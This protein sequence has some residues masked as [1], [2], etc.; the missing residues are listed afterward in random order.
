MSS[1]RTRGVAGIGPS[2][3]GGRMELG[4]RGVGAA[5]YRFVRVC[6]EEE[7]EERKPGQPDKDGFVYADEVQKVEKAPP[8][9]ELSFEQKQ[10]LREEYLGIGG[11]QNKAIPNYFLYISIFVALLAILS[12]LLG[13]L[14]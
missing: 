6:A 12:K 7:S 8:R 9:K 14:D 4:M 2:V 5:T 13:Y 3:G 10:K 11:A 1:M